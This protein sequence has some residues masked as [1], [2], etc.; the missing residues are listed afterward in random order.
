[1]IVASHQAIYTNAFI[2]CANDA[3]GRGRKHLNH[4]E[5]FKHMF[6]GEDIAGKII[7]AKSLQEV[8]ELLHRFPLYGDFMSYHAELTHRY[9]SSLGPVARVLL[10]ETQLQTAQQGAHSLAP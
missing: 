3:Y 7:S 2:L 10:I 8:Y 5:L 4:I 6:F 9:R 1:M